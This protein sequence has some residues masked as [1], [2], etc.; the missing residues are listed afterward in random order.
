MPGAKVRQYAR[1]HLAYDQGGGGQRG[2]LLETGFLEETETDGPEDV[3]EYGHTTYAA[4]ERLRLCVTCGADMRATPGCHW[5][6]V[7]CPRCFRGRQPRP[8][9]WTID[10]EPI[11]RSGRRRRWSG[12]A[13]PFVGG[14]TQGERVTP[15]TV[16]HWVE[17][18]GELLVADGRIRP[19]LKC[20]EPTLPGSNRCDWHLRQLR[21][22]LK[23]KRNKAHAKDLRG[24]RNPRHLVG[25][26]GE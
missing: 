9:D 6:R 18:W 21:R 25:G 10:A 2:R 1:R 20:D 26:R 14:R 8:R 5:T 13:V 22:R 23:T 16:E 4:Q 15:Q 17:W 19:C 12:P 7:V 3:E 11:P 24:S